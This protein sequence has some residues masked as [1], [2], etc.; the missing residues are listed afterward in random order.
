VESYENTTIRMAPAQPPCALVQDLLPLYLEGEVSPGST[1]LIVDHLARCERCAGFLAGAQSVRGQLAIER[2]ARAA[3]GVAAQPERGAVMRWRALLAGAAAFIICAAGGLGSVLLGVGMSRDAGA[4][5]AGLV[6]GVGAL[7]AL[8]LLARVLGPLRLG[9]LLQLG[10]SV[11]TGVLSGIVI[12]ASSGDGMVVAG[13]LL[14]FVATGTVC[15][16]ITSAA[17][18]AAPGPP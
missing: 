18:R 1:G 3:A 10:T 14:G 5:M 11:V 6:F 2:R 13:L 17:S 12:G 15:A 8:L 9:R 16:Q 7:G 4:G